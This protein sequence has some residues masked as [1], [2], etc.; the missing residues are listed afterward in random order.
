MFCVLVR[1]IDGQVKLT[2]IRALCRNNYTFIW[3][4]P[5]REGERNTSPNAREIPAVQHV[6]FLTRPPPESII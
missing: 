6:P 1:G 5:P 2:N 3:N 4:H